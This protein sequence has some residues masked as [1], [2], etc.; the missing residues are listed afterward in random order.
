L[1]LDLHNSGAFFTITVSPEKSVG[2]PAA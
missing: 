1:V 2:A